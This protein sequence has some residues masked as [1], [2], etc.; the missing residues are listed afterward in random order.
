MPIWL[1]KFT[2]KTIQD[3]FDKLSEKSNI[4]PTKPKKAFGPD[5]RPSYTA[6][7]SKN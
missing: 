7:A 5:I 6:K 4:Q 2:F 1:R 3:H